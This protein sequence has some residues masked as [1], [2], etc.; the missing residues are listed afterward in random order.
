MRCSF[1]SPAQSIIAPRS[2]ELNTDTPSDTASRSSTSNWSSRIHPTFG[3]VEPYVNTTHLELFYYIIEGN[4]WAFNRGDQVTRAHVLKHAFIY[5]F[6]LNEL[7]AVSALHLSTR[8]QAQQPLYREEATRLQ[9]QALQ[10]FNET[11]QDLNPQNI[12]PVFLFSVIQG[13]ATFFETFH[14]PTYEASDWTFF[15]KIIQ[16]VKLLQ[17]VRTIIDGWW[18]FLITSDIKDILKEAVALNVERSDEVINQFE[19]SRVHI[20]QSPGLD[21]TQAAVCDKVIEELVTIYKSAFGKGSE[22]STHDQAAA[23]HATRWLI[24]IPPAYRELLVQRKLE[25]L[26]ILAHFAVILHKLRAGWTVGNAGQQLILAVE[27]HLEASW[28]EAL[29]WPKSFV[30]GD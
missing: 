17:G 2:N 29:S 14:D 1:G 25:A 19:A 11:T 7:L 9:S 16:S 30:E 28:H 18:D 20:L 12:I 22:R 15:E 8:R 27:A 5:P 10:M 3:Q 26:L 24:I 4:E 13:I 21:Q 23:K 6:L